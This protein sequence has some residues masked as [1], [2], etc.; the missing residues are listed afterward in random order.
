VRVMMESDERLQQA[1][2]RAM[3][4]SNLNSANGCVS[5][6][7]SS[8]PELASLMEQFCS[9]I[10]VAEA[11]HAQQPR[12]LITLQGGWL[13]ASADILREGPWLCV[14]LR[15]A[16]EENFRRMQAARQSLID[17][18]SARDTRTTVIV[19]VIREPGAT[20]KKYAP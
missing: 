1:F 14:R 18:L 10:C 3:T 17:A 5:E 7:Q 8:D 6:A 15:A 20:R 13:G 16:N 4:T 19:E 12:L 2:V 9:A 11:R